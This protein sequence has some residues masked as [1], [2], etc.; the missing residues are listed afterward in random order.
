[1]LQVDDR[2]Q[3]AV[4]I[5][6]TAQPGARTGHPRQLRGH[7]QHFAGFLA[8]HQKQLAGQAQRHAHPFARGLLFGR[9]AGRTATR[10]ECRQ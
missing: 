10:L 5:G 9:A 2:Q 1:M 7:T 8:R 4:H 3:R 6:Q